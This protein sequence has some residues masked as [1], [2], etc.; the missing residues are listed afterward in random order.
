[1][2]RWAQ[3]VRIGPF[4]LTRFSPPPRA[5]LGVVFVAFLIWFAVETIRLCLW[6]ALIIAAV[7]AVGI[8]A[9]VERVRR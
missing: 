1:M 6:A 4:A 5:G 8:S 7:I 3:T 9:I 2:S